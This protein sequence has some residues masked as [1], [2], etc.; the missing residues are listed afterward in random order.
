[1]TTR[2][3]F[4]QMTTAGIGL[5][6]VG[7]VVPTIAA[8]PKPLV[9][10]VVAACRRLAPHGWR[11]LLL[12]V[13]GGALD[14][15]A[16]DLAARLLRPL[17]R[18][19]RSVPGFG[20]FAMAGTRPIEPGAP[21]YSLLYHAFAAPTV[22]AGRDGKD[23]M[24]FPTLPEIE[25]VEDFVYG[26]EPPS[27]DQLRARAGGHDLGLVVFAVQYRNAPDSVFGHHAQLCFARAGIARL[28]T[29]E[30]FYDARKRNFAT[31][32]EKR[33]FDFRVVPRRFAAY[34]AMRVPGTWG[35]FG[36]QDRLPADDRRQFWVPLHKLFNG[37]ECLRD[38]DLNVALE[39]GLRNDELAMFHR[40]LDV[41]GLQN[42]V[43]GPALEDYPFTL[44]DDRIGA[45]SGPDGFGA[46]V[47]VPLPQPVVAVPKFE[48][49]D[50]TFPVDGRYTSQPDNL[51][52]G[53]LQVLPEGP[54]QTVPHYMDD[55]A[56]DTQRPA[57]EYVN[58]RHRVNA[59]GTVTNLNHD[60]DLIE[61]MQAG[62]YDALHYIDGAGDG[63]IKAT[64]AQLASH[65]SDNVPAYSMVGLPDFFPKVNQRDLMLW[66]KEAVPEAVRAALWMVPPLALSQTRIAANIMLPIGFSIEDD[67]VPAI[68]AQ[69][70][71]ARGPVQRPNGPLLGE[72][73]GLPDGSPGLFD[74][75][76]DTSQGI[77]YTDPERPVQ[78]F[79]AGHGLGSPFI[80]DAKLCAALGAYWPGVAPDATRTF[81]PDKRLSGIEYPYPSIVPLTDEEIGITSSPEFGKPMPWDGV[82]GPTVIDGQFRYAQYRNAWRTDYIDMV[83]TM[84]AVLTSR[85]DT[86][87]YKARILAME[88]VYWSL[89]IHDPTF[90]A[91]PES[92]GDAGQTA[93]QKVVAAKAEWAVLSFRAADES[94]ADMAQ[95]WRTTGRRPPDGPLHRFHVFRW[96]RESPAPNDM[97]HVRVEML[98]EAIAYVSG[99][100][101]WLQRNGGAWTLDTSMPTS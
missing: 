23:L 88:A 61:I 77:Y 33:P 6:A 46:G 69:P 7:A 97:Y 25:A 89:G 56:Q 57:P 64:C 22:V 48:G 54:G 44:K 68:V 34:L 78:K 5:W 30:P 51:A 58:I 12:D 15:D 42:N 43:S 26:A 20:D 70:H 27:L 13:T 14:L 81:A 94:D 39:R 37:T 59:D 2:R 19:D 28:G 1:M 101:V 38:L 17:G 10:R 93:P 92:A 62:G 41:Q 40:F 98:E 100:T 45:L 80:E 72:K 99:T 73:V 53:S 96:G 60:P 91:D 83:G 55:A 76:W 31:L 3:Q 35:G 75:G 84:T 74:P 86:A 4:L 67:T 50:L 36:P 18:I 63:W 49:R 8:E 52:L 47:L 66:W 71:D 16:P 24:Q 85:I 9:E 79:L 82:R 29:I 95:A 90:Q 11:D 21:D 65:L 87:E 32:D